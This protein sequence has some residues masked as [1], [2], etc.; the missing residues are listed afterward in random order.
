MTEG[1]F[2]SLVQDIRENGQK[3]PVLLFEGL[4]V[5]GRHRW[6]ACAALG[7]EPECED[8]DGDEESLIRHIISTNL[9]RRHLSPTDRALL[10]ASYANL[11]RGT[12]RHSVLDPSRD[13]SSLRQQDAAS[14]FG[15]SDASITRAKRVAAKG[16][17]ELVTALHS[18]EI[19]LAEAARVANL[20]KDEQRAILKAAAAIRIKKVE[21]KRNRLRGTVAASEDLIPDALPKGRFQVVVADFP[22][23][24]RSSRNATSNADPRH[25]YPTMSLADIAALPIRDILADDALLLLWSPSMFLADVIAMLPAFGCRYHSTATWSKGRGVVG[26]GLLRQSSEFLVLAV[27]GGGLG[28]PMRQL[29][30]VFDEKTKGHSTKPE[31]PLAWIEEAF[32][33]VEKRCELFARRPRAGWVVWGASPSL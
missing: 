17:Q 20:S 27:R 32:P 8:W 14:L 24:Y 25:H 22:F 15:V 21:E 9:H 26:A 11:P 7:I 4:V 3:E 18:G 1:E 29:P 31:T 10:A 19:S 6:S 5:D 33:H 23:D 2:S 12:N 28:K 13:G 30:S 16:S